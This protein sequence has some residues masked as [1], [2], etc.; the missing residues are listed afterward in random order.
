[1]NHELTGK[2][3]EKYPGMF[4]TLSLG[5][6]CGD[7]WY[8]I[9]DA[10]CSATKGYKSSFRYVVIDGVN[11]YPDDAYKNPA[12]I[13]VGYKFPLVQFAQI[14]EKFGGIRLYNDVLLDDDWIK[15]SKEYPIMYSKLIKEVSS[16][17]RGC[18][19]MAEMMSYNTCEITGKPGKLMIRGGWYKT[20][21]E[22]EAKAREFNP[23]TPKPPSEQQ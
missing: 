21:C 8:N 20:L 14:K 10:F 23:I 2:L 12:S 15:L 6:D 1:M 11:S 3:K 4:E 22:E 9:I 5:I 18:E 16:Y 19:S 13:H 7:G 17:I